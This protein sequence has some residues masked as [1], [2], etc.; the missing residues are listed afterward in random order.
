MNNIIAITIG[1]IKGIGI[2]LLLK[3]YL[4]KKECKFILFTNRRIFKNY[5]V[6]N[7]IKISFKLINDNLKNLNKLDYKNNF[8]IYDFDAK[9][10]EQNAYLALKEAYIFTKQRIFSGI[11]TLP[12][13]KNKIINK[14][15][16]SFIGQTEYFQKLDNKKLSNMIFVSNKLIIT[17]LT[18]H[19]PLNQI[20]LYLKKR[21]YIYEKIKN[22]NKILINNFKIKKPKLLIMGLNPHAGENGN[23]G[24]EENVILIPIIKKLK[25]ENYLISGPKSADSIFN[26]DNLKKYD[27]FISMYH[28][29][30]LI[31]F[32]LISQY[33]GL[34]YTGGIS[35][36]RVSPDH[37][38]AYDVV[39]K[40]KGNSKSLLY[41][42]NMLKKI[43]HR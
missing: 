38:T 7:K 6:K 13:N 32:K 41:C 4:Q 31:P 19:I 27:C 24:K 35:I 10:N 29:Q 40:N 9:N 36:N 28:D 23:I 20:N 14:I 8:Y 34:N 15:D 42:F 25:K 1:D 39:G 26:S 18:T 37:G 12:L 30:A 43:T 33:S 5:L 22:I 17:T 21:N 3:I 2:E 16:S 11:I